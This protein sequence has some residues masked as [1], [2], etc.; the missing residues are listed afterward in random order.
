MDQK[1][2]WNKKFEN[3]EYFYGTKA[4]KFI[5]KSS[6]KFLPSGDILCL[7]EGEGRNAVFLAKHGFNVS[8]IDISEQGLEKLE[9]LADKNSVKI[10][11]TCEDLL[12]WEPKE[13]YD[14]VLSSFL[15]IHKEQR[16]E[17]FEN[18]EES[19]RENGLFVGEFFSAG[20]LVYETGGP[21][22]INL[23]YTLK[24]FEENFEEC[25]I[26][27]LSEDIVNLD[28]GKAHQGE[29]CVIRVILR[30]QANI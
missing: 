2:L 25:D 17:F 8:A 12:E 24:D 21:K 6:K 23:L 1:E 27:R 29:A 30:K 22:E 4:N 15:H 5:E 7:G 11:T 10:N 26:I 28:E 14:V 20:Q 9:K 13:R 18:I 16:K 3:E 19:L